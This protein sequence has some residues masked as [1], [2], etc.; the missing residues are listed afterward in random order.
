MTDLLLPGDPGFYETLY[1]PAPTLEQD[2]AFCIRSGGVLLEPV[3]C[4]DE[5]ED[6]FNSG[7]YDDVISEQEDPPP[8]GSSIT[9]YLATSS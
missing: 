9:L 1:T 4:G 5:L 6:Y 2:V 8:E 3:P 7:E